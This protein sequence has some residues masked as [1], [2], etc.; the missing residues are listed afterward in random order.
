VIRGV[1]LAACILLLAACGGE[2]A[3][4]A[5]TAPSLAA[6]LEGID[7]MTLQVRAPSGD[8][9]APML[10]WSAVDGASYY[11][12]VVRDPDGRA[13]WSWEGDASEVAVGAG[14]PIA[15]GAAALDGRE[16]SVTAWSDAHALAASASIPLVD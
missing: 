8:D 9:Q 4:A 5:S 10:A 16:A 14:V 3:P 7:E 2:R 15:G 6:G 12:V 11:R 1:L 13:E